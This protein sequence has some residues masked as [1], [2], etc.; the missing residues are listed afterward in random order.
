MPKPDSVHVSC[1]IEQTR[2]GI[3]ELSR[4]IGIYKVTSSC[5]QAAGRIIDLGGHL[6]IC[7]IIVVSS[8]KK[9]TPILEYGCRVLSTCSSQ[10]SSCRED[11]RT[12]VEEFGCVEDC[13]AGSCSRVASCQQDLP[14]PEQRG[15]V[16]GTRSRHTAQR[17][18]S[19]CAGVVKL[20]A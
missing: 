9:D 6:A 16:T 1:D 10:I 11:A 2:C 7:R 4:S 8:G 15:C 13:K 5:R 3:V 17:S 19:A 12:R 18:E 14:V 20:R